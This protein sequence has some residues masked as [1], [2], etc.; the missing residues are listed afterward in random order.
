MDDNDK[1]LQILIR[2]HCPGIPETE[3]KR[4]F[5]PFY[6]LVGS[7]SRDIGGTGLGL[8]IAKCIAELHG[9]PLTLENSAAGRPDARLILPR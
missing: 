6:R 9:G 7:R 5:E 2:D 4:I 3:L 8:T 1:R